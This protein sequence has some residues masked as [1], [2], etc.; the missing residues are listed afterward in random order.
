MSRLQAIQ[1]ALS[2]INPS[3]FQELC[4][5]FLALNNSNY[6]ALSRTGSQYGKQKTTPGT[7]DSFILL[8]NSNFLFVEHSTNI[9]DGVSKLEDDI[10]KCI[11]V[12]KTGVPLNQIEEIILCINFDLKAEDVQRLKQLLASTNI[13][14][15][16][17]T[18]DSLSLDLHLNHRN[19]V[20]QYLGLP[21]DTGQIVSIQKFISE[22]NRVSKGIATPLD[23]QFLHRK[24][25]MQELK[26]A[27]IDNDFVIL[28]GAAGVG[29]TKLVLEG[30]KDFLLEHKSF[31][32]YCISYKSHVLLDDLYQYLNSEKDYIL[33]VD[34]ANRI[35]AFGQIAGFY[36]ADRKGQ[37]KILITVRDYAYEKMK[38][39]CQDFSPR[40]IYLE[41]F[42]DE[43]IADIVKA[44]PFKI[45]NVDYHKPIQTIA[46]GNPRI[47]IMAAL[48]AKQRQNM[49][50]LNDVA[51]LFENYFST[52]I[53]DEEGFSS[54][55][56]IK[57]LG[58]IAFFY[59]LPFKDRET[60][61]PIL[62][63]FGID[64]PLFIDAIEQLDRLELLEIS[65]DYVKIPEQNLAIYFFYRAFIK[66]ELLS[67]QILLKGYFDNNQKRF[68]DC[69]IPANNM[70]GASKVSS[71]LKPELK[72]YLQSITG[73]EQKK[74][75]FLSY[76]WY[77]LQTETLTFLFN[78]INILSIPS[79]TVYKVDYELNE[80]AHNTNEVIDLIGKFFGHSGNLKDVIQLAFEY[81]R[82]QPNLLPELIHKI[83][84]KLVFNRED[85]YYGFV[86]QKKLF[87]ILF[88][89]LK[90]GDL[91]FVFSFFELAKTFLSYRFEMV[92]GRKNSIAIYH[93]PIPD[94]PFIREFRQKIWQ[95]VDTQFTSYPEA[96]FGVLKN[97]SGPTPDS[98][99][100]IMK[101]DV[102][103][104]IQIIR[105]HLSN[106]L[107]EHCKYVQEQ[108]R[109]FERNE[110]Y[111][112]A[113]SDLRQ[114]FI[115]DIYE[116]FV[117]IDWNRFRDKADYEFDDYK[118]YEKLKEKDI[119]GAFVFQNPEEVETFLEKYEHL[120]KSEKEYHEYARSF[121]IIID[122][123]CT[124][125]FDLGCMMIEKAIQ[126]GVRIDHYFNAVFKSHLNT[127]ENA[128]KLWNIIE[129]SD[130]LNKDQWRLAFFDYLDDK[131]VNKTWLALLLNTIENIKPSTYL[132][133]TN[134][135]KY[136][137]FKPDLL[138][139]ILEKIVSKSKNDGA[140]IQVFCDLFKKHFTDLGNDF[141]LIKQVYL[142]QKDHFDYDGRLM[143]QILKKDASF[144]LD[145]VKHL[146][147]ISK[148]RSDSS[149]WS[150]VWEVSGIEAVLNQVFDFI[151]CQGSY[152]GIEHFCNSFF[153]RVDSNGR[154]KAKKFLMDYCQRNYNN[155]GKIDMVVDIVRNSMKELYGDVMLLFL[156]LNQEVEAFTQINWL[157]TGGTYPGGTIFGDVQAAEWRNLL[158]IVEKSNVGISLIPIKNYIN[159][160]IDNYLSS[161]EVDR[162]INFLGG[163]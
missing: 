49:L 68:S 142:L 153:K 10:A 128:Q 62:N 65:Y 23:N 107:F 5:S 147:S 57:C 100:K 59:T 78:S 152:F 6:S 111:H 125:N 150:R 55:F 93:Y 102:Q 127:E 136:L 11:N 129:Q 83:R 25:E 4:D 154:V 60:M 20:H 99:K 139:V 71:K 38:R 103:Y 67:F 158:S 95:A 105:K 53:K 97:Y 13:N 9:T 22:Y 26:Q 157:D 69:V 63:N 121:A 145:L 85:Q 118:E 141:D 112:K 148:L 92:E 144:L 123:N 40:T 16:L 17:H 66:D 146:F 64:Y 15:N 47:A 109:W 76:F 96:S 21:L 81:V 24:T 126:K 42:T 73:N 106:K 156:S 56:N 117:K 46:D 61:L 58:L 91:L 115:N 155:T 7:P 27:I 138:Q 32:A 52:F 161:A 143:L 90:K 34:D 45:L 151:E 132:A 88:D 80:F 163:H 86:R 101:F 159:S 140:K 108:I 33:F 77:Y 124:K 113:F 50:A 104:V 162:K 41:K 135:G 18:R 43:Q 31:E 87:E 12:S 94:T 137:S 82:K 3:I 133:L 74:L 14:L 29:K 30:A 131:L 44:P 51:E 48:L 160:R 39:A 119:R 8:P 54:D 75:E 70:F 35:D 1:S 37:L 134:I 89:G 110:V 84:K 114:Q 28:T 130:L 149:K 79:A 2:A 120:C 36:K 122:E 116:V 98:I 72:I 19:L